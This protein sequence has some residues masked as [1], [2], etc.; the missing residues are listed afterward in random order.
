VE[1]TV[2]KIGSS[3]ESLISNFE[4]HGCI[5]KES[6]ACFNIV[7]MFS[8]CRAVLLV[9]VRIGHMISNAKRLEKVL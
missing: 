2:N 1:K 5:S 9:D 7:K 8:F 4:W 6:N 3:K